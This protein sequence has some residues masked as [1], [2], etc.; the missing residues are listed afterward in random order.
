MIWHI[1][2]YLYVYALYSVGCSEAHWL[3]FRTFLQSLKDSFY[4][5]NACF[6]ESQVGM[7]SMF[8]RLVLTVTQSL[9]WTKFFVSVHL[10]C[11]IFIESFIISGFAIDWQ[12]MLWN[13]LPREGHLGQNINLMFSACVSKLVKPQFLSFF[14]TSSHLNSLA[15]GGKG[16]SCLLP[17]IYQQRCLILIWHI[18]CFQVARIKRGSKTMW[19]GK[20]LK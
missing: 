13:L 20:N 10:R 2:K 3:Y 18:L 6:V 14:Y 8:F 19:W 4:I 11:L 16:Q 5:K 12:H 1:K 7:F 15:L 17:H 9:L